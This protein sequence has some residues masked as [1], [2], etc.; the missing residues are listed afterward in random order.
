MFM[1]FYFANNLGAKFLQPWVPG[2][3]GSRTGIWAAIIQ[4]WTLRGRKVSLSCEKFLNIIVCYRT[5]RPLGGHPLVPGQITVGEAQETFSKDNWEH[6]TFWITLRGIDTE[7]L[8]S[9]CTSM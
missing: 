2:W 3:G 1:E 9:P 6:K 5:H 8:K 7:M 4:N